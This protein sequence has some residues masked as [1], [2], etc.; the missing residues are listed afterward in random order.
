M[1]IEYILGGLLPLLIIAGCGFVL[2]A[3][4]EWGH[5]WKPTLL[6]IVCY[7]GVLLFAMVFI[8]AVKA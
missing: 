6:G 2:V 8:S 7:A 4:D 3:W 5:N 1:D